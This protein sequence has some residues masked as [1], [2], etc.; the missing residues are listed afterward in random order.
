MVTAVLDRADCNP[1][2]PSRR[3]WE[4]ERFVRP[5]KPLCEFV[6]EEN[7]AGGKRRGG[8]RRAPEG[9][10]EFGHTSDG[11]AAYML[12]GCFHHRIPQR[13]VSFMCV[14]VFVCV[15]VCVLSV[16][17]LISTFRREANH[18]GERDPP[19]PEKSDLNN[20]DLGD[21]SQKLRELSGKV[22]SRAGS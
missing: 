2:Q 9:S 10:A 12:L 11:R 3:N 16:C 1:T 17:E 4:G 20:G 19:S 22:Y 14:S 7:A 21:L 18:Y 13:I 6:A 8:T 15:S 5:N